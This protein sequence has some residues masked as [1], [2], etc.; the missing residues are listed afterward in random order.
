MIT[1]KQGMRMLTLS[2]R[3]NLYRE[4]LKIRKVPIEESEFSI[5]YFGSFKTFISGAFV[6]EESS[7]GHDY[8]YEVSIS[9][10]SII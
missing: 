4:F 9:K 3:A 5:G 6:W 1:F 2:E 7:L 8:W 10:N